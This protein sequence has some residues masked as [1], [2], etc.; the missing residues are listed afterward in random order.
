MF[1]E[2]LEFWRGVQRVGRGF[3]DPSFTQLEPYWLFSFV[4]FQGVGTISQAKDPVRSKVTEQVRSAKRAIIVE[5]AEAPAPV[6]LGQREEGLDVVVPS[7]ADSGE[8]VAEALK[9]EERALETAE[10]PLEAPEAPE[11]MSH[12]EV[13]LQNEPQEAPEDPEE[14][15]KEAPE[16][17]PQPDA[18]I[19]EPQEAPQSSE[20]E[21]E[22]AQEAQEDEPC[23]DD[24]VFER[25]S[26]A[27]E[28]E[29]PAEVDEVP[30]E[31]DDAKVPIFEDETGNASGLQLPEEVDEEEEDLGH[32]GL[33]G[34]EL[35]K[36]T[37]EAETIPPR[38]SEDLRPRQ[39]QDDQDGSPEDPLQPETLPSELPSG[40]AL[41]PPVEQERVLERALEQKSRGLDGFWMLVS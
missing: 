5:H 20:D 16:Q 8:E 14:A 6:G 10:E 17:A 32:L 19:P 34:A 1:E 23:E 33:D 39:D 25:E 40:S 31:A 4:T 36:P 30:A 12:H 41:K 11:H 2:P 26:K 37:E 15:P 27:E 28:P 29:V 22:E 9:E 18:E 13:E 3:G 24:E 35:V 7:A 21:P 38:A